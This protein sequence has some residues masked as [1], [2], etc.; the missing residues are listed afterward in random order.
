MTYPDPMPQNQLQQAFDDIH[1]L[2]GSV[3]MGPGVRI[4]RTMA[5]LVHDGELTLVNAIRPDEAGRRALDALGRVAHVVKIGTHGMDDAWFVDTYGA[6][7]WALPGVELPG[8]VR[9]LS[10]D[11]LP[12]PWVQ[13][14]TFE[15]TTKPEGALLAD[16]DG[17]VLLTCDSV[18]NWPDLEQ[19]SLLAKPVTVLMGFTKRPAVIGPP[20]RKMMTPDGGSLQPDFERLAELEFRH[21]IGGHG[22]PLRD[23]AHEALR[24]SIDA[25]FA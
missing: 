9:R 5:V 16:R 14:F 17:G 6:T 11:A 18:Q 19:C 4:A 25:T 3:S 21:L 13:L 15:H 1:F 10:A 23:T 8:E 2:V 24:A 20:W 12:V 22:K 7:R